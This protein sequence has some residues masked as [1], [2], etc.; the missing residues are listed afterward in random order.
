[1]DFLSQGLLTVNAYLYLITD[2]IVDK[3]V[4]RVFVGE[5]TNI[6]INFCLLFIEVGFEVIDLCDNTLQ[7][8]LSLLYITLVLTFFLFH[9]L[10]LLPIIFFLLRLRLPFVRAVVLYAY[11][12][13]AEHVFHSYPIAFVVVLGLHSGRFII[14]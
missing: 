11:V 6:L 4:E 10:A 7:L 2:Y 12:L 8:L 13:V 14:I 5:H 3:I 1:M 9:L